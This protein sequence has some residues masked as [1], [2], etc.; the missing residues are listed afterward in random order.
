VKKLNSL[1]AKLE[2]KAKSI[3][4]KKIRYGLGVALIITL[5]LTVFL[6]I[7]FD[8]DESK[9]NTTEEVLQEENPVSNSVNSIENTVASYPQEIEATTTT[10]ENAD[11][12]SEQVDLSQWQTYRSVTYGIEFNYPSDWELVPNK[13]NEQYNNGTDNTMETIR[14]RRIDPTLPTVD[15]GGGNVYEASFI[16]DI[17]V[18]RNDERL[19][20]REYLNKI[21]SSAVYRNVKIGNDIKAITFDQMIV[22]GPGPNPN[23]N[24]LFEHN[25][26]LFQAHYYAI[27][28]PENKS[29]LEYYQKNIYP[30]VLESIK[31]L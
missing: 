30:N 17:A 3:E 8:T 5:L 18:I 21:D 25:E 4:V 2:I 27:V 11:I 23:K 12:P 22:G 7:F 26:L 14:I 24:T 29:E 1:V 15:Y 6:F 31:V 19:N 10:Q 16:I 28:K 20:T 9:E 13:D